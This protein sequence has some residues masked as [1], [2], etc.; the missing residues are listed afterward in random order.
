M[1]EKCR[2]KAAAAKNKISQDID[3]VDLAELIGVITGEIVTP[4]PMI[5]IVAA[6]KFNDQVPNKET[7]LALIRSLALSVVEQTRRAD[8]LERSLNLMAVESGH[9]DNLQRENTELHRSITALRSDITHLK[10]HSTIAATIKEAMANDTVLP[11]YSLEKPRDTVAAL[12]LLA[13][14]L[15][16]RKES[17]EFWMRELTNRF[18]LNKQPQDA[19]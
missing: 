12:G 7:M 18:N 1:C 15:D 19:A 14:K 3:V 4:H 13:D 5:R 8:G 16:Q 11:T 2:A 17:L 6:A 9:V 10:S